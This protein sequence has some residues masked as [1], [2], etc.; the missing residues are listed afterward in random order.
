M[1]EN[2]RHT[3]CT[4][5]L[6][7]TLA[8]LRDSLEDLDSGS[9]VVKP[10]QG[11]FLICIFVAL[12]F[13]IKVWEAANQ[14]SRVKGHRAGGEKDPPGKGMSRCGFPFPHIFPTVPAT[15][16]EQHVDSCTFGWLSNLFT[17]T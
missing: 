15:R 12:H 11:V 5:T 10:A 16:A 8:S 3:V 17:D 4:E 9:R 1:R 14:T 2:S 13:D 7:T 6:L